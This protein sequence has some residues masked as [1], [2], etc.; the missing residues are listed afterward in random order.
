VASTPGIRTI[1]VMRQ[2]S[3]TLAHIW[4]SAWAAGGGY[5]IPA[6]ALDRQPITKGYL[7]ALYE[8]PDFMPSSKQS[9]RCSAMPLLR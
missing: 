6:A 4:E 1:D 8:V 7:R 3:A 2:G 9:R 5:D